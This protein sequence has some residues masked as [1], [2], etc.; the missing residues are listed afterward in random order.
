MAKK[1]A[2][3]PETLFGRLCLVTPAGFDADRF[4][5]VLDEALRSGDVATLILDLTGFSAADGLAAAE[6]LV[7]IAQANGVAAII[8]DDVSIARASGADGIQVEGDHAELRRAT[9][10]FHPDAIVG[11]SGLRTR[12]EA[13]LAGETECDYLFF[14]RLDGD[15]S[16]AIF[17][18]A[19]DMAAWWSAVFEIPA[20]VM[21]GNS[22]ASVIEAVDARVEFVALR[23]AI[24]NH[25][26]GAAAAVTEANRLIAARQAEAVT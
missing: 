22:V 12:H 21:G 20:I 25:A 1:K 10:A 6:R 3:I 11:A 7:P 14:G 4:A 5:P 23:S 8:V 24:W 9:E 13:M 16:E 18:K 19:L 2:P 17:D 15:T 26:E